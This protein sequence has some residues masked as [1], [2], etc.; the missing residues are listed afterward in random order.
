MEVIGLD[1]GFGYT[2]CTNG[3][4]F[5]VFKSVFGEATEAQF[6]EQLLSEGLEDDHLQIE[7]DGRNYFVGELA[8]RQSTERYF[9]LDQ[10]QFISEFTRILSMCALS[11]MVER[12]DPVKVVVGLPIGHYARHRAD[13]ASI[14]KGQHNVSVFTRG[15]ERTETVVRVSDLRVVPQ[16]FGTIMNLMLNDVGEVKDKRFLQQKV[17]VI[18]VGFRT[19]DFTIAD[20]TRYSERGSLTTESGISRAFATIA[21]KLQETS[22]VNIELYRMFEAVDRGTIKIHGK[23][24]DLKRITEQAFTQ[25]ASKIAGDA[26]RLWASDWDLDAVIISGGGGAVLAPFLTPQL[27][28][29]VLALEPGK[30]SRMNNVRGYVKYAKRL[31]TRGPTPAPVPT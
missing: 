7:L 18:D 24:Y 31:W 1:I 15:G 30:D 13:L 25:L 11:R 22:G 2:K 16:P 10:A 4:R 5:L 28:G 20:R 19:A 14:L 23:R 29:E 27:K 9:T 8:E 12:Q 21:A 26:N 17:G 3:S 6:R